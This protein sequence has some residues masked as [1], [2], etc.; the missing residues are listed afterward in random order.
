[1]SGL[2][3]LEP[4]LARYPNARRAAWPLVEPLLL[5]Y[6]GLMFGSLLVGVVAAVVLASLRRGWAALLAFAAGAVTWISISPAIDFAYS[7]GVENPR[8]LVLVVRLIHFVM[9]GLLFGLCARHVR[10][11]RFLGGRMMPAVASY[12]TAFLL[13]MVL[14]WRV[15]ILL[16]GVVGGR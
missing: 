16:L 8:L 15:L 4:R 12:L 6:L 7:L 13:A 9:G 1:M 3:M 5:P 2:V 14:P 11:H 10:G